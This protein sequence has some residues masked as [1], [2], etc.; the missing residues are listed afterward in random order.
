VV[1]S[2]DDDFVF[3]VPVPALAK[4]VLLQSTAGCTYTLTNSPDASVISASGWISSS[5][6]LLAGDSAGTGGGSLLLIPHGNSG[7]MVFNLL[8]DPSTKAFSLLQV[9]NAGDFLVGSDGVSA[10]LEYADPDVRSDLVVR[11]G[12]QVLGVY[13]A[14]AD[15]RFSADSGSNLV[16]ITHAVWKTFLE[17][18]AAGN[19]ET[20]LTSVSVVTQEIF[21]KALTSPKADLPAFAASVEDFT[22]VEVSAVSVSAVFNITTNGEKLN[23][24]AV[25]GPDMD[26]TWRLF[27]M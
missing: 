14:G 6:Q 3:P 24:L 26:G 7:S 9:L 25:F 27:S 19:A 11:N 13:A 18:L 5:Y 15:G 8:R 21:R 1:L 23:Y 12:S 16:A 17:Q 22:I 4:P 10:S 2:L 20:A